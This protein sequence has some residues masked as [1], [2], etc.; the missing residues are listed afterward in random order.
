MS[1]TDPI[2]PGASSPAPKTSKRP[3]STPLL[4]QESGVNE[5]TS[6]YVFTTEAPVDP[7]GPLS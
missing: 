4:T 3:W 6:K 5:I 1:S 2:L 7:V